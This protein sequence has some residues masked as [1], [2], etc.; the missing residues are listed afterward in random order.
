L[1]D[2]FCGGG[3]AWLKYSWLHFKQGDNLQRLA[4]ILQ[5]VT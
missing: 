2:S 5:K 3:N 4:R 1:E